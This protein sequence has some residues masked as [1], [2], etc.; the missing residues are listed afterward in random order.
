MVMNKNQNVPAQ[1]RETQL[2]TSTTLDLVLLAYDGLIINLEQAINALKVMPKQVEVATERIVRVQKIVEALDEG[3]DADK[4]EL[5]ELLSNFYDFLRRGLV[6]A[7]L[8]KST[9]E[10]QEIV[11]TIT[12]VRDYW[13]A[14]I[15]FI[16]QPTEPP[17]PTPGSFIPA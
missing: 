3:L 12:Q 11:K 1:Y 8:S 17:P 9:D 16:D 10:L 4:G 14:S 2:E 7:N 15:E 13:Q 5:P 6:Q